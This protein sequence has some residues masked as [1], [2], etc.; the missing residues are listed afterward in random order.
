MNKE[1]RFPNKLL[2]VGMAFILAGGIFLLWTLGFFP[3][4]LPWLI[5]L[6]PI[7][8]ILGGL[9]ML[10]FVYLKGKSNQLTLPGMILLLTGIFFLL[11]NTVIPEKSFEKIWPVF[12]DIA[13]L[14]L[15]PYAF[16]RKKRTRIGLIISA[17][18]LIVLSI[19][20]FPFSMKLVEVS[21]L[22]F[23]VRW[24]PGLIII[25][26]LILIFSFYINSRRRKRAYS[27]RQNGENK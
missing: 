26:G 27:K 6:W 17:I 19:I 11:Y 14:S 10:Y 18:T 5:S 15:L 2:I 8:F 20:F 24:W 16:K 23:A 25:I 1:P 21:F 13:G 22:H 12:M 7:P 9:T 4:L 3:E